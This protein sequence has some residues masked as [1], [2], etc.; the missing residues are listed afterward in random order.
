M[1]HRHDPFLSTAAPGTPALKANLQAVVKRAAAKLPGAT[2]HQLLQLIEPQSLE[3]CAVVVTAWAV[4]QFFGFGE[5]ADVVLIVLGRIALG[6]VAVPAGRELFA[7][8]VGTYEARGDDDLDRAAEHL[9]NAVALITV[10]AALAVL[11]RKPA[12]ALKEQYLAQP[13]VPDPLPR[14]LFRN[15]PSNRWYGYKP[16]T[17]GS[18]ALPVGAGETV[19]TTGDVTYSLQG[20]LEEQQ[21]ARAHEQFHQFMIPKLNLLR[22]LRG[23]LRAQGYNRSY[24]LRALEEAMAELQAQLRVNG[25]KRADIVGSIRFPVQ[26]GYVTIAK[27]GEEARGLVLGPITGGG[28]IYN[29]VFS[30]TGGSP[31]RGR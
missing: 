29:V 2:G 13:G 11:L 31:S 8:A 23:F 12:G 27:I 6:A 10:Q 30:S 7:F 21:L 26:A 18:P 9:A 16:S 5:V 25:L 24:I 20:T 14:S 15:L 17:V 4:A 28:S 19:I 3:L 22:G 1:A